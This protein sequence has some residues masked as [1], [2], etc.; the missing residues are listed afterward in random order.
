MGQDQP[1]AESGAET[2]D[3]DGAAT[4]QTATSNQAALQ[5]PTLLIIHKGALTLEVAS[6]HPA[7]ASA[8]DVVTASGGFVSGSKET[9]TGADAAATADYRIPAD[10]WERT[11]AG[12]RGSRPCAP[13]RSRPTR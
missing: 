13:R 9:G 5:P 8:A 10:A 1:A 3:G 6:L 4:D 7:V 12:L 2:G 11:L